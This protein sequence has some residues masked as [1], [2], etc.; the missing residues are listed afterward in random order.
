MDASFEP[1]LFLNGKYLVKEEASI[2]FWNASFSLNYATVILKGKFS[3]EFGRL[4]QNL[5]TANPDSPSLT[6][7]IQIQGRANA[8][9]DPKPCN[10]NSILKHSLGI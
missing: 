8:D 1:P 4:N 9:P 5:Y 10:I 6:L 2:Q 3:S 7:R